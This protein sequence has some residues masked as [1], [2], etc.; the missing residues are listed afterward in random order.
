MKLGRDASPAPEAG[1]AVRAGS[2]NRLGAETDTTS[3]SR[4]TTVTGP[5]SAGRL[6]ER[7]PTPAGSPATSLAEPGAG[8]K[9]RPSRQYWPGPKEDQTARAREGSHPSATAAKLK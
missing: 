4:K 3:P 7:W 2:R 6:T 9:Q 1:R 5:P 8:E